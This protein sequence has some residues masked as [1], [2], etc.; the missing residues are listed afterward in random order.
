VIEKTAGPLLA[1][2]VIFDEYRG[3]EVAGRSVAWRLV[4]RAPDR[5]LKEA[6]ADKAV[7]AVLTVLKEQLGVERREA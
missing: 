6:E 2:H 3:K 5:T 7:R 1:E 4:F